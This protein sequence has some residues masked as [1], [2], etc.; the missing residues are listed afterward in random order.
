[1]MIPIVYEVFDLTWSEEKLKLLYGFSHPI[2]H[3][4]EEPLQLYPR[5]S[6]TLPPGGDTLATST[7]LRQGD[8]GLLTIY[9]K[10]SEILVGE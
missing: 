5:C 1:M 4:S 3:L 10:K 6:R 9:M 2:F 7:H 8:H